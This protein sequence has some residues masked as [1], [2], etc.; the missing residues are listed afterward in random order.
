MTSC[1]NGVQ[2]DICPYNSSYFKD[3]C[4][5][6]YDSVACTYPLTRSKDS[7]GGSIFVIVIL[8][9][10]RLPAAQLHRLHHLR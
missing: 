10:F 3:C 4:P 8:N 1:P 5:K 7:C 9:C 6:D 2:A